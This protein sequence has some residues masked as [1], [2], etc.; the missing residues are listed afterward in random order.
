MESAAAIDAFLVAI[1]LSSAAGA[2]FLRI[3]TLN[4]IFL[5]CCGLVLLEA[6]LFELEN[7]AL[8]EADLLA[9]G[10]FGQRGII[11]TLGSFLAICSRWYL[12]HLLQLHVFDF[13]ELRLLLQLIQ[14]LVVLLEQV[15]QLLVV[16]FCKLYVLISI[17]KSIFE[18]NEKQS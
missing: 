8:Q 1:V 16:V 14:L 3:T 10:L 7:Q 11:F 15:E 18:L 6:Y 4:W 12:L 5:I 13:F 2:N 17:C 9:D